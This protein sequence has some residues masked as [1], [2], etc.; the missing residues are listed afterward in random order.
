[1]L[2]DPEFVARVVRR[3][4][5]TAEQI[6]ELAPAILVWSQSDE[7]VVAVGECMAIGL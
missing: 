5:I 4:W 7:S 2:N 1:R 3:G 6:A